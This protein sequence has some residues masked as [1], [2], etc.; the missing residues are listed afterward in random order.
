MNKQNDIKQQKRI[1]SIGGSALIEGI[2]MRGPKRTTVACRVDKDTIYTEDI[3]VKPLFKAKF[4]KLPLVRGIAGM[5]DSMRLSY[6]A[7]GL[8][9]DK[10]LESGLVEEE[11]PSKFEKWLDDKLGDK[12]MNVIMVIASILGVALALG[13]FVFLPAALFDWTLAPLFQTT[14]SE[15]GAIIYTAT[16]QFVKSA[17][18]GVL[19]IALFIGYLMLVSLMSDMKRV[20]QYHGAEHKTIFCYENDEELTVENVRKQTRFHP[21]CGTSFLVVTLLVSIFVGLFIP[22]AP[23]GIKLLNPL[24]RLLLLPIMV[25]LG[26]EF[27]KL[28]GK[29]DNKF[30]HILATPGLWAQRITTREPDDEMIECAIA[31]MTAV[32][33]DDGSDIVN[34][35]SCAQ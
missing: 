4:W 20:F 34:D 6:K 33:P 32:I 29:H 13:L 30:T 31:A 8:A 25:G 2:M 1:T 24:F 21:R 7:L 19:K 35:C 11:E 14:D 23:F 28:C 17:F 12:L 3:D 9:A 26:Y 22:V 10:A 16:G 15:T 18:C 27:I 5:I